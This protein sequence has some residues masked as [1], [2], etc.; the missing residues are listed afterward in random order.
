M[1]GHGLAL[2]FLLQRLLIVQDFILLAFKLHYLFLNCGYLWT[3][4][5]VLLGL[6]LHLLLDF[7][8]LDLNSAGLDASQ[9]CSLVGLLQAQLLETDLVLENLLF[10]G[11]MESV[12]VLQVS[13]LVFVGYMTGNNRRFDWVELNRNRL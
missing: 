9:L 3:L 12:L 13:N 11:F 2:H 7:S 8:N 6:K 1:D 4:V 5:A 10:L